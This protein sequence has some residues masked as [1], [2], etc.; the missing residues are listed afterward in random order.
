MKVL[1]F[2]RTYP[3]YHPKKGQE[4]FFEYK[5]ARSLYDCKLIDDSLDPKFHDLLS[6]IAY[7]HPPKHHTIRAGHRFKAG[8][9]FRPVVWGDDINPKSGRK[10][11]YN[12]K[13]ITFAPPIQVKKTWD[14]EMDELGVCS[15]AKPG[16]Q[17]IYTFEYEEDMDDLIAKNDGLQPEDFYWWFSRSPDFKKND[18][19]QG[20]IICWSD[21]IEYIKTLKQNHELIR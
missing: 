12:S 10:G 16:D 6:M 21:S 7:G 5:I 8:D 17:Q 2:S 20:Q 4:T 9:W 3:S 19:F 11:P 18:G 15:I 1:T 13:Q 14:F